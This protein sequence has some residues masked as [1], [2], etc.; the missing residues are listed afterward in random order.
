MPTKLPPRRVP[1]PEEN[2]DFSPLLG[3]VA[4]LLALLVVLAEAQAMSPPPNAGPLVPSESAFAVP[5]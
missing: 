4:G 5:L 2:S 3:L 1:V